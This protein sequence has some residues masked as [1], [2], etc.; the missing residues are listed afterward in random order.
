MHKIIASGLSRAT[1]E[2]EIQ[3]YFSNFGKVLSVEFKNRNDR[4]SDRAIID[5][6]SA[7]VAELVC[8]VGKH[9]LSDK[10]VTKNL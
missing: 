4:G 6:D 3:S 1:G 5:F 8:K 10:M 9:Y 2:N 7:E